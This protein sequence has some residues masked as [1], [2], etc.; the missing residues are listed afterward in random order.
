[1]IN[2]VKSIF[3]LLLG[4]LLASSYAFKLSAV[5]LEPNMENYDE[6]SFN[7]EYAPYLAM[8]DEYR[9]EQNN[10]LDD[11]PTF[12]ARYRTW[13]RNADLINS[14]LALPKG[15]SDAGR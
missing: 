2:I 10:I 15:M 13:K 9:G 8:I 3:I 11:D 14:L 12:D 4:S 1:M 7:K 6:L 5:D